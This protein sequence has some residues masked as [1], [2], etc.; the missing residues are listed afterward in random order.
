MLG[1]CKN[2]N[3]QILQV[4]LRF[5]R[6]STILKPWK[7]CHYPSQLLLKKVSIKR[8]VEVEEEEVKGCS[9]FLKR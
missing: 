1:R 4:I 5:Q 8:E 2:I 3:A 9:K 6:S 7:P